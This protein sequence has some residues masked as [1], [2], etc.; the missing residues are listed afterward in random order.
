MYRQDGT[1]TNSLQTS[2][3]RLLELAALTLTA[4][5]LTL[6]AGQLLLAPLAAA[7][8][9]HQPRARVY[10]VEDEAGVA[11]VRHR[12]LIHTA[13]RRIQV[14]VV[15]DGCCATLDTCSKHYFRVSVVDGG[16]CTTLDTCSKHDVSVV[17]GGCCA[18]LDTCEEILLFSMRNPRKN[19]R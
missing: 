6:T 15:D 7:Q 19:T 9:R 4:A 11:L 5:A 13:A 1:V 16:C 2:Q 10:V 3:T 17:D 18:T 12:V 8:A 14:S